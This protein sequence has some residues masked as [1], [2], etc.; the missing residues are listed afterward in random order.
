MRGICVW[1]ITG[2]ILWAFLTQ[3]ETIGFGQESSRP[4][5]LLIISD[6]QAWTDYGFMGH[7]VIQTPHLD[8]LARESLVYTR[9][10]VPDSLCRPSLA[11][12]ITGLYPHQHG[13]TGN[14]PKL[15]DPKVNPMA[16]RARPEFG[17]FYET[18]MRRIEA[19]PTLPRLLGEAG[20]IS[21]QTGKWWEGAYT[22]GGFTEGMTHGDPKR[23]GRHGDAGLAIGRQGLEPIFDFILK[24]KEA[25]KP[26]FVWYAPMMPH[27]PHTPPEKYLK[28]YLRPDLSP[29]Q[30]RYYAMCEWFDQTCGDLI[31]FL[32]KE[33]LRDSTLIVYL[34]DN[35]WIQDPDR[36]NQ[37]AP[38]SKRSPYDG[39][40]RT[41]IML[42]W[43]GK[44]SPL[45]DDKNLAS[46]IDIAPTVLAA[47]GLLVPSNLPGINLLDREAVQKRRSIFGEIY[48]HDVADVDH[49][50]KSLSFRW[51]IQENWK[52]IV[53]AD[54][55]GKPELY[56]VVADPLETRD[57][58]GTHP[59]L[60]K[61]LNEELDGWWS[62][63]E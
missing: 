51:I 25:G 1:L 2:G 35:G 21:L 26:F 6:D 46:S 50:T 20:Y 36:P 23:G 18:L 58:A 9:G 12:I 29:A 16:G 14:D 10:Y 45:R 41:P 40:I 19:H 3:T 13:I 37:F 54:P 60:V 62:G 22:R 5:V 55:R 15:P 33:K 32:E 63:K 48:E 56:D 4:N 34:A 61:K 57:L 24:A 43:P 38:R 30:S 7:A 28:K 8:R 31:T 53:P 11:T 27:A 52:L 42:S 39:G 44:I 59:D 49:P 17:R 47:C